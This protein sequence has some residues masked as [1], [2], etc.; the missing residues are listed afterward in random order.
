VPGRILSA[1]S[2]FADGSIDDSEAE[3]VGRYSS[4]GR[5]MPLTVAVSRDEGRTWIHRHNILS[6]PAGWYCY[7]AIH[8]AGSRVLLAFV[9]GGSGLSALSRTSMAWFDV[10]Q[11][12]RG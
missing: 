1:C 12:Y 2:R 8:F 7:T 9:A 4:G 3:I 11:L 5:R 6:D 10:K